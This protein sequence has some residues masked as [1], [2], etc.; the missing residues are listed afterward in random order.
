MTSNLAHI[1]AKLKKELT[2]NTWQSWIG[3]QVVKKSGKPFASGSKTN[4]V[5]ALVTHH[6]TKELSFSF[7]EDSSIVECKVLNKV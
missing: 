7:E 4:T 2:L 6:I 5:K 3:C 1:Q